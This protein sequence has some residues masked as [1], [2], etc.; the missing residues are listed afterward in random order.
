MLIKKINGL[1][2]RLKVKVKVVSDRDSNFFSPFLSHYTTYI[3]GYVMVCA[4]RYVLKGSDFRW[5]NGICY[6]L[7]QFLDY[8]R[9]YEPCRGRV[10]NLAHEQFGLFVFFFVSFWTYLNVFFVFFI[11]KF[12]FLSSWYQWWD[13]EKFRNS[14]WFTWSIYME[15]NSVFQ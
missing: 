10:V 3:S 8:S 4:H 11:S 12:R 14:Y 2:L 15:R 5:G 7:T 9:T 1:V 13:I 6:S